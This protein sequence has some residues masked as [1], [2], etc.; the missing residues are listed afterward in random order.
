MACQPPAPSLVSR[1]APQ[2]KWRAVEIIKILMARKYTQLPRQLKL[3]SKK[4]NILFHASILV[5][6][7]S[8]WAKEVQWVSCMGSPCSRRLQRWQK[9]SRQHFAHPHPKKLSHLFIEI[10]FV[11]WWTCPYTWKVG[12][13]V[14]TTCLRSSGHPSL[15]PDPLLS[16]IPGQYLVSLEVLNAIV[17][18]DLGV[19]R[20][21]LGHR[22]LAGKTKPR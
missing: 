2:T 5:R 16:P 7:L 13:T 15:A 6:H 18:P 8:F 14:S 4:L 1:N 12:F 3:I 11:T 9:S 17:L 19:V 20:G 21:W 22:T 10:V